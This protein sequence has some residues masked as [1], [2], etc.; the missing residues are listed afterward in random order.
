M[1]LHSYL[2]RYQHRRKEIPLKIIKV[3]I[4]VEILLVWIGH[5]VPTVVWVSFDA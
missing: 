3:I 1:D 5:Y 4:I 2:E